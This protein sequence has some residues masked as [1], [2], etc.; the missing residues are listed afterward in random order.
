MEY[1]AF[2]NRY[3]IKLTII[4]ILMNG[5]VAAIMYLPKDEISV[6]EGKGLYVD[7]LGT[8]F[9]MPLILGT[10]IQKDINNS[11]A[12][13]SFLSD[14]KPMLHKWLNNRL[15]SL[16]LNNSRPQLLFSIFSL[17]FWGIISALGFYGVH[18]VLVLPWEGVIMKAL[19]GGMVALSLNFL[20]A[21]FF[22]EKQI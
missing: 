15:G 6:F 14:Y 3:L 22:L 11:L 2:R 19:F 8:A 16:L 7:F 17:A 1:K 13:Y 21:T 4:N 20:M 12:N 18:L 9:F 10:I 5:L